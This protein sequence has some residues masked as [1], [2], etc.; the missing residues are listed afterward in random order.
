MMADLSVTA[1]SVAV[2]SAA[3]T[4][5]G[6]AGETLVAGKVVYE[7]LSDSGKFYLADANV[8]AASKAVGITLGGAAAG[9]PVVIVTEDPA[10]VPGATLSLSV[11][12]DSG[13]Y[14]LS[15][16]AGGIAPMDDLAATMYP[17]IIGVANSASTMRLS[18]VIG[19]GVLVA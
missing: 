17:V 1:A 14:V 19:T 5:R 12:A 10:F 2:S 18:I 15:A 4:R 6:I 8:L 7:N 13:V 16:T 3:K 9:Q 11:A